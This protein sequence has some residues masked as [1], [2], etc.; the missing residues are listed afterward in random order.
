LLVLERLQFGV[1]V[2]RFA[3]GGLVLRLQIGLG[4]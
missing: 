1:D 3:H 2:A 4:G